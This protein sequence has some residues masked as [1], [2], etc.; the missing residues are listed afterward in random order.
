MKIEVTPNSKPQEDF[1]R[2]D[3]QSLAFISGIGA[4]KTVAGIMRCAL[5]LFKW[6][7]GERGY[8][9]APTYRML[10]NVVIPEMKKWGLVNDDVFD[11]NASEKKLKTPNGSVLVMESADNKRKIERLRG[12]N[13]SWFWME[14]GA[15]MPKKVWDIMNGRLRTGEYRNAFVTTTPKGFNWIYDT[16]VDNGHYA[17]TDIP[18]EINPELP[19]DYHERMEEYEGQFY[20][21][22]ILGKFV[23]FEGLVFDWVSQDHIISELPNEWDETIYGLD[24][25]WRNPTAVVVIL[26][27]GDEYYI[28]DEIY[29]RKLKIDSSNP[30]DRDLVFKLN[31]LEE[32]WGTGVIYCDPS[33][34]ES[35]N[36]LKSNG[37][38]ARKAKNDVLPGIQKVSSNQN[39]IKINEDCQ[40]TINEFRSYQYKDD[41]K[42]EPLDENNHLMD[43]LRYAIFTHSQGGKPGYAMMDLS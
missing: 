41:E 27:K 17:L 1:L 5:N 23:Q 4:G 40:N 33:E 7:K 20:Q 31:R 22:E 13:L 12:P 14:E 26:K 42:E 32:R 10:N 6:N 9:V 43:A 35:L 39:Y 19:E 18:T 3:K 8:V 30:K 34:P 37:F 28:A 25:G 15:R 2:D 16:F 38:K 29:E 11:W 24:W 21:Q 36:E